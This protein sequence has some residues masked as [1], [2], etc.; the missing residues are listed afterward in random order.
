MKRIIDQ[1]IAIDPNTSHQAMLTLLKKAMLPTKSTKC[2][3]V[4]SDNVTLLEIPIVPDRSLELLISFLKFYGITPTNEAQIQ[5][6]QRIVLTEDAVTQLASHL[7]S[8]SS[9]WQDYITIINSLSDL[10]SKKSGYYCEE[11]I[12]TDEF[13]NHY[14][15]I[16]PGGVTMIR[17]ALCSQAIVILDDLCCEVALNELLAMN[18]EQRK[19]ILNSIDIQVSNWNDLHTKIREFGKAFSKLF[20]RSAFL[21]NGLLRLELSTEEAIITEP[22]LE[23]LGAERE[24]NDYLIPIAIFSSHQFLKNLKLK[25]IECENIIHQRGVQASQNKALAVRQPVESPEE[26]VL[27]ATFINAFVTKVH[28]ATRMIETE[29]V[30]VTNERYLVLHL[31]PDVKSCV[32]SLLESHDIEMHKHGKHTPIW[33][34]SSNALKL[35]KLFEVDKCVFS[36]LTDILQLISECLDHANYDSMHTVSTSCVE[37][38][39][40]VPD[41]SGISALLQKPFV[42]KID[43]HKFEVPMRDIIRMPVRERIEMI[44][45]F[46]KFITERKQKVYENIGQFFLKLRS[47]CPMNQDLEIRNGFMVMTMKL[48][49]ATLIEPIFNAMDVKQQGNKYYFSV[50]KFLQFNE[51]ALEAFYLQIEARSRSLEA[52]K[53]LITKIGKVKIHYTPDNVTVVCDGQ[54]AALY[55]AVL[56]ACEVDMSYELIFEGSPALMERLHLECDKQ[57]KIKLQRQNAKLGFMDALECWLPNRA[58][59]SETKDEFQATIIDPLFVTVFTVLAIPGVVITSAPNSVLSISM[60]SLMQLTQDDFSSIQAAAVDAKQKLRTAIEMVNCIRQ[61]GKLQS[62]PEGIVFTYKNAEMKAYCN[63]HCRDLF[64]EHNA[65]SD[66]CVI[67]YEKI[68]AVDLKVLTARSA[69]VARLLPNKIV[70][71]ASSSSVPAVPVRATVNPV[72]AVPAQVKKAQHKKKKKNVVVAAAVSRPISAPAP[73]QSSGPQTRQQPERDFDILN[74]P[75][76]AEVFDLEVLLDINPEQL[77]LV[78]TRQGKQPLTLLDALESSLVLAGPKWLHEAVIQEELINMRCFYAEW[79]A[80]PKEIRVKKDSNYK[81]VCNVLKLALE[82]LLNAIHLRLQDNPLCRQLSDKEDQVA[83]KIRNILAHYFPE[84]H[85]IKKFYKDLECADIGA[86]LNS[87][88]KNKRPPVTPLVFSNYSQGFFRCPA[89]INYQETIMEYL[90]QLQEVLGNYNDPTYKNF[91]KQTLIK[92]MEACIVELGELSKHLRTTQG[93]SEQIW[94]FVISCRELRNN[95]SH[96]SVNNEE[97][98]FSPLSPAVVLRHVEEG[99]AQLQLQQENHD[100]R[101]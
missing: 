9:S 40:T 94:S 27:S 48:S 68:L 37:F 86:I 8:D 70:S 75:P 13:I 90:Q 69:D 18:R 55:K 23:F 44:V 31:P 82:R 24:Q 80:L 41:K 88:M 42:K 43:E 98:G 20:N 60:Q 32:V 77:S 47:L 38:V 3:W 62:V 26:K 73:N 64:I 58:V 19:K 10:I 95:T 59:W 71:V 5:S 74:R 79:R 85:E 17:S 46:R 33:I 66:Q 35:K 28:G 100:K 49:S 97:T 45:S 57:L 22:L 99:I 11:G 36:H 54:D 2:R 25:I 6:A 65:D 91:S 78:P 67:S 89:A 84:L 34:S 87:V 101:L 51:N 1:N 96:N 76:R 72:M 39:L 93:L 53:D 63:E 52:F 16:A 83:W 81:I 30:T 14:R 56:S 29:W 21:K 7:K 50:D 92:D 61:T 15:F 12:A 4:K